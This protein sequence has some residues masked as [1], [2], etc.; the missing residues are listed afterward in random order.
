MRKPLIIANWKMKILNNMIV[1]I[2]R[3]KIYKK[4]IEITKEEENA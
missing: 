4:T 1:D 3:T 2:F